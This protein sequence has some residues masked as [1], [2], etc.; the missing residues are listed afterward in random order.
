VKILYVLFGLLV[1]SMLISFITG[2][3]KNPGIRDEKN[4]ECM[5]SDQMDA[6][7]PEPEFPPSRN[8]PLQ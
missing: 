3:R 4:S 1:A 8:I 5:G 7:G 6:F 2:Y